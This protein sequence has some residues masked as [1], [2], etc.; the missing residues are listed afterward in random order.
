MAGL[1][2][3]LQPQ[4]SRGRRFSS[5]SSL[6]EVVSLL[7][8]VT[9]PVCGRCG[10][11]GFLVMLPEGACGGQSG[12]GDPQANTR[13]SVCPGCCARFSARSSLYIH[14]KKHLQDVAATKSRCPVSSC[15]RLFA[16][17]HSVKAHVIRQHHR[18]PGRP[19]SRPRGRPE[20][21]GCVAGTAAAT[22]RGP[23]GLSSAA[24]RL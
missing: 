4:M 23:R 20:S 3:G 12:D 1:W 7:V 11:S 5:S 13:P 22:L 8:Q 16:S 19:R 24:S 10:A 14:S 15:H 9:R 17:K 21:T 6:V 2:G 18:H